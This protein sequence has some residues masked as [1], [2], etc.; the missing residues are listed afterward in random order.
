MHEKNEKRQ[1]LANVVTWEHCHNPVIT[2]KNIKKFLEI[3]CF[4][5]VNFF[6]FQL[7]FVNFF[8]FFLFLRIFEIFFWDFSM[9]FLL[10]CWIL[11]GFFSL[12]LLF[13]M[14]FPFLFAWIVLSLIYW[15]NFFFFVCFWCW[16][17]GKSL[18]DDFGGF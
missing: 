11:I 14:C 13:L 12:K 1:L 17:Y 6:L 5:F 18:I 4:V 8:C 7:V 15:L 9:H 3:T 10:I 16:N 2:T